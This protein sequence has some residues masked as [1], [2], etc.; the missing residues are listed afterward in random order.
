MSMR[1]YVLSS[2]DACRKALK[3]LGENNIEFKAIDIRKTPFERAD[4]DALIE[5]AGLEVVF[6]TNSTTWRKMPDTEKVGLDANRAAELIIKTPTLMKRPLFVTDNLVVG[7]FT[8]ANR[9]LL[10]KL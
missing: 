10:L 8:A 7:G 5:R 9:E 1:V 6:N 2:C 4:L 3:W